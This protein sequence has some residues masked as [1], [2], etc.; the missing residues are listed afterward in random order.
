MS[1]LY[2][3]IHLPESKIECFSLWFRGGNRWRYRRGLWRH[4]WLMPNSWVQSVVIVHV[5]QGQS[6]HVESAEPCC[7]PRRCRRGRRRAVLP[8]D[9]RWRCT[10]A[11]TPQLLV[12]QLHVLD[13]ACLELGRRHSRNRSCGCDQNVEKLNDERGV[14]SK[15]RYVSI[16]CTFKSGLSRTE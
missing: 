1:E 13:H 9:H 14:R 16:V 15:G 3:I 5:P 10:S 4:G 8:M 7:I 12:Q 11:G 2:L 6:R